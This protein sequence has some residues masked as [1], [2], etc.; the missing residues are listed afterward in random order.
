MQISGLETKE[1]PSVLFEMDGQGAALTTMLY[2]SMIHLE[3]REGNFPSKTRL[4]QQIIHGDVSELLVNRKLISLDTDSLRAGTKSRE[5]F[6]QRLEAVSKEITA[7]NDQIIL[8]IDEIHTIV[9]AGGRHNGGVDVGNLLY[10]ML[11]RGDLQIVG[12]TTLCGY[13][14]YIQDL[15]H[16]SRFQKVLC[17]NPATLCFIGQMLPA[18]GMILFLWLPQQF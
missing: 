18:I 7:S 11:G 17:D 6:E 10:S 3:G 1:G 15:D 5:H 16:E 2:T 13:R 4:A 12:A 14:K 8:F 9:G